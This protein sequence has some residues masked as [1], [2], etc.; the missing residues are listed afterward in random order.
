MIVV[1]SPWKEYTSDTG[2]TYYHNVNTKESKWTVPQELEDLK[3]RIVAEEQ[4]RNTPI[5]T[6]PSSNS[7]PQPLMHGQI[8]VPQMGM[9]SALMQQHLQQ[10][11]PPQGIN[12]S[13]Y[14]ARKNFVFHITI[15]F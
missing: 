13:Q 7:I 11:M 12:I 3:K 4:A 10:I 5:A 14:D 6:T 2:K 8:P 15:F 1:F 9:S